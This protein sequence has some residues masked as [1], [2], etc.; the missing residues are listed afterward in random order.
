MTDRTREEVAALFQTLAFA[1]TISISNGGQTVN[2][3]DQQGNLALSIDRASAV[4]SR[5]VKGTTR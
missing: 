4:R 1:P 2:L 5:Q 3:Q